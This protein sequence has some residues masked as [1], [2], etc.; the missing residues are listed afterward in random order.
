MIM[1]NL[2]F[3]EKLIRRNCFFT[4]SGSYQNQAVS[5]DLVRNEGWIED[6]LT[7][8]VRAAR[9]RDSQSEAQ[10][11][12]GRHGQAQ[13]ATYRHSDPLIYTFYLL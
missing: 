5:R 1:V 3:K 12:T 7:E 10:S 11:G 13:T 8:V 2:V 4:T 6:P 9:E